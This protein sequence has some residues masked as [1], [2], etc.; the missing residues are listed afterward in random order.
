MA[1]LVAR[2]HAAGLR[3]GGGRIPP[4]LRAAHAEGGRSASSPAVVG[5]TSSRPGRPTGPRSPSCTAPAATGQAR[6]VRSG[7]LRTSR[8]AS[9]GRWTSRPERETKLFDNGFNPS[10][11]PDGQRLAFD[12]PLTGGQRVWV[13]DTRGRNP[14]QVTSD[15]SEVVV[16]TQPRWSPDGSKLV[17]RRIEKL[18]RTSPSR[19]SRRRRSSRVTDD[20]VFDTDPTWSP[21][22]RSIYFSS[23]RGGGLNIWRVPWQPDGTPTARR[24]S[25]PPARATTSSHRCIRTGGGWSSRCAASTRTSG[26]CRFHPRPDA[27]PARPSRC[28]ARRGWRAAAPGRPTAGRSRST[29]TARA[30]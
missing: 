18:S 26:G 2:R 25:S 19:T 12:A 20:Y 8:A 5:I 6:A 11:S 14:R 29:P 22:G 9:S 13:A 10:Y 1:R 4:A 15:S 17:F 24:S 28:S 27:P 3:R 30:R 16:H 7:R 23:S 21:D